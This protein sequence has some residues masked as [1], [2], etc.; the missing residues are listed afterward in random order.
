MA[1][2]EM[3]MEHSVITNIKN[4]KEHRRK[5]GTILFVRMMKDMENI[6]ARIR[7]KDPL[8]SKNARDKGMGIMTMIMMEIKIKMEIKMELM[9]EIKM[10]MVGTGSLKQ[11]LVRGTI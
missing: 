6:E 2:M 8:C 10:E 11:R 3:E 5:K 9:V 1:R 4:G 7:S